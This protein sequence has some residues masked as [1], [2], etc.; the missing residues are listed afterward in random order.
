MARG[1]FK[2]IIPL[3]TQRLDELALRYVARYAATAGMLKKTLRRHV[4]KAQFANRELDAEPFTLHI[5]S[6][7][8]KYAAKGWIDDD[9]F[10]KRMAEHAGAS[11]I[12]K[13][14]L[15]QKLQAKG[16]TGDALKAA[17]EG[18]NDES[19]WQAA[20]VFARKKYIG[21][22][23]RK[24]VESPDKEIGRLARAGF[25]LSISRKIA[26]MKTGDVPEDEA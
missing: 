13:N 18:L 6:I 19:D 12:S 26:K 5:E 21:P 2:K 11:G 25:S 4:Q 15:S 17:T 23:R 16:I 20:L 22:W 3:T 14:K 9:G 7:L 10:A 8:K 1:A 24:D